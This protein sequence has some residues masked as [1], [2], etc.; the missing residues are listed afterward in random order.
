[1]AAYIPNANGLQSV[2]LNLQAIESFCSHE[3]NQVGAIGIMTRGLAADSIRR[4]TILKSNIRL[5]RWTPKSFKTLIK[6]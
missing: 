5:R 1:M 4:T 2:E 3:Q 6:N